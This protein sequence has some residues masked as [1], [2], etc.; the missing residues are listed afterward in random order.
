[1]TAGDGHADRHQPERHLRVRLGAQLQRHRRFTFKVTDRGD[2]DNCG[3]PDA[4]CAAAL[5]SDTKTFTIT[6]T[7]VNDKPT[8]ADG[9]TSQLE[10][11]APISIDLRTLVGDVETADGDLVYSIVSGVTAGEGTLTATSPNGTFDVR[12]GAQ[13]Q[14]HRRL[15]LQGHRPR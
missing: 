12:L 13:L 9:P 6:V 14:R 15:H 5:D 4:D 3:A 11:A 10:D 8:G 2:P 1:M 7:P